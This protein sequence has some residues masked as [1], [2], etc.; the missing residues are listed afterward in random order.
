MKIDKFKDLPNVIENFQNLQLKILKIIYWYK[1]CK[2]L[3]SL[4]IFINFG[5]N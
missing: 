5:K 4:S 3:I 1:G 2:N